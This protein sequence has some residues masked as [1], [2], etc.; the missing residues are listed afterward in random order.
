MKKHSFLLF[1]LFVFSFSTWAQE[2]KVSGILISDD[3]QLPVIGA[4]V[5]V[6]GSNKVTIS[7]ENG[8]FNISVQKNEILQ[9]NF[10]G[11]QNMELRI[12]NYTAPLRIVLKTDAVA[13]DEVIAVGYGTVKKSDLT[14]SVA[15]V[16]GEQL[17]KLPSSSI[18]KALQGLTPGVTVVANSGQPGSDMVVRI[19]GIG[20]VNDASP[21]YVVDGVAV[22][23]INFLSPND[24]KSTEVL[25]DASA[26]AIYGSRGANGVILVTTNQGTKSNKTNLNVDIYYGTQNRAKKLNLMNSKQLSKFWG[27]TGTTSGEFNSWIYS[28][29]ANSKDYIPK[30]LDYSSFETDWQD[31]VFDNN[32]P[33]QSYHVS[34]SGGSEK[35]SYS[36]SA[37]YFDQKGI[38]MD[39][40]YKRFTFRVNS[41][42]QVNDWLKVGE[43]LS[44]MNSDNRNA[45]NN[46]D[47]YSILNSAIRLAPW[48]PI[49]F[50][51]G[52]FISPNTAFP[53]GKDASNQVSASSIANYAN[54]IS[55]TEFIHPSD[56]W[57]RLVGDA[58][59][60]IRPIKDL[61]Y[62]ADFGLDLSYGRSRQFKEVYNVAPY[63]Q[64]LNNFVS[65]S[66]Q[67]YETWSIEQTLT[68]NKSIGKHSFSAMVGQSLSEY[69]YYSLGG[70]R[71][72]ITNPIPENWYISMGKG[73]FTV[74]DGVGRSRLSSFLGRVNY[75]FNNRYLFTANFRADGS[76]KFPKTN[77]WGYF[78]SFSAGWKAS[79]EEFFAP[80]KTTIETLKVRAGWGQIGNQN[81]SSDNYFAKLSTGS[82][83]VSYVLGDQQVLVNGATMTN[84]PSEFL[85]WETT[86]QTNIG[87]DVGMLNNRLTGSVDY[88]NKLTKDMLLNVVLPSH[89]GMLFSSPDNVGEVRNTGFEFIANWRD[90]L[91]KNL[92]YSFGGNI[93]SVSNEFVKMGTS[94]PIYGQG[95]KGENLIIS[96]E[97]TPLYS[98]YGYTYDGIL[99]NQAE[100]DDY[101]LKD[102]N[103]NPVYLKDAAGNLTLDGNG[104][105]QVIPIIPGVQPGDVRYVDI[106][107]DGKISD[108]DKKILGSSFP[109]FTYGFNAS[110]DYKGF[111]FSLFFQGVSGN[112]IYNCNRMLLEGGEGAKVTNLSTDMLQSFTVEHPSTT[113]PRASGRPSNY[114]ASNRFLEDGSYL[115]LKNAQIG[116]NLPKSLIAPLDIQACRLYV[117]GSN[118]LTFTK[119]RGYDPEASFSGVDRG[120]YPQAITI[121]FGVKLD[122]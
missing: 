117:S 61:V 60:E 13:L 67:R 12:N 109:T 73:T 65:S 102:A 50:P 86:E 114:W 113:I 106:N 23:N 41:S 54:P 71:T 31:V 10:M 82:Q 58:Y 8:Q 56:L 2:Y 110:V 38:I 93:A 11:Y 57:N 90:N 94:S 30:A 69:T 45:P 108:L 27:Y 15:S 4:T 34:A 16:S 98:F 42:S 118:L 5:K 68:Y 35:S 1:I 48:D 39:S 88:Y 19:R 104:N 62:K 120:N 87:V 78:P 83:F 105:P 9:I 81:I 101:I 95:F 70:S 99:Q 3:D 89:I 72:N 80:L 115:R 55:M 52:S 119:Y 74:S 21:L 92:G 97:G 25:K 112:M 18:D 40:Y 75:S 59:F 111:D 63:D 121:L 46:N 26:T 36:L 84:L 100:V 49:R 51:Q 29:F 77:L 103:G 66:F 24:I 33:I 20:T 47:N 14:G 107:K 85:K 28:N 37:G 6:K 32:A 116:Y 17:R 64:M 76:T 43:N 53:N 122:L 44:M 22:G 79:E 91:T 7:D 96:K